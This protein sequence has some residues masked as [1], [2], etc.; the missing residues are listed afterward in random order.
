LVVEIIFENYELINANSIGNFIYFSDNKSITDSGKFESFK[1]SNR[2]I[3]NK[4]KENKFISN[5][6]EI[7][8]KP[9]FEINLNYNLNQDLFKL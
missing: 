2:T 4:L 3:F 1:R 8:Q 6:N 7:G 5:K 9:N